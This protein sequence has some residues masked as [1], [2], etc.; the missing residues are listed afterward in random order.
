MKPRWAVQWLPAEVYPSANI[1]CRVTKF[2]SRKTKTEAF[3]HV[4]NTL[5]VPGPQERD[6][7]IKTFMDLESKHHPRAFAHV[8][9]DISTLHVFSWRSFRWPQWTRPSI[10]WGPANPRSKAYAATKAWCKQYLHGKG[11]DGGLLYSF[12]ADNL[13]HTW[14]LLLTEKWGCL[15]PLCFFLSPV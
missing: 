1:Y 13:Q 9:I 7:L 6:S 3:T 4:A 10:L 2:P 14:W 5:F 15:T 11:R 12:H 8:G